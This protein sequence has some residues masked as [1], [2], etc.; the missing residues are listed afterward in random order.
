MSELSATWNYRQQLVEADWWRLS[1]LTQTG[2]FAA[3]FYPKRLHMRV[4][5]LCLKTD[6]DTCWNQISI[7]SVL[8]GNN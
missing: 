1:V 4:S 8:P 5:T 2:D 6:T 7:K 3:L